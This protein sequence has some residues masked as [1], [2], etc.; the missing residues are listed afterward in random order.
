VTSALLAVT[1]R[2]WVPKLLP[3]LGIIFKNKGT[4][5]TFKDFVQIVAGFMALALRFDAEQPKTQAA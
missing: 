1:A 5:G 3:L 4:A 2:W